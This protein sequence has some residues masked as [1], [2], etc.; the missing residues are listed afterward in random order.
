M[1]SG[2]AR[3]ELLTRELHG[4]QRR[5]SEPST[6]TGEPLVDVGFRQEEPLG[7]L[8]DVEPAQGLEREDELGF[9]GD[10]VVAAHEEHPEEIVT[11]V[12]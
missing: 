8:T 12:S 10:R 1:H 2:E 4:Q 9:D 7:D 5:F 3:R 11:D 6:R